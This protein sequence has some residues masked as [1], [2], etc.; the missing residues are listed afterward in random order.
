M[1]GPTCA[2]VAI[3]LLTVAD[4]AWGSAQT[5]AQPRFRISVNAGVQ[6]SK[7]SF[8]SSTTE[9]VYLEADTYPYDAP[10]FTAALSKQVSSHKTG[11][12]A[13]AD[14]GVHLSR[15]VGVGGLVRY[16]KAA[17]VF[18]V[19]NSSATVRADAGGIQ[20]AAGIRFFF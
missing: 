8:D 18:V 13:G 10:V 15:K 7:H 6:P 4:A 1:R 12:N 3:G 11:F 17:M 9:P 5:V 14:L 20:V 2:A 16:S 19:P